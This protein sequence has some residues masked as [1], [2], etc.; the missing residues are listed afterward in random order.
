MD[1]P[2]DAGVL[3]VAERAIDAQVAHF[4]QEP[5]RISNP[6]DSMNAESSV[7]R[8]RSVYIVKRLGAKKATVF[9]PHVASLGVASAAP[10]QPAVVSLEAQG[11]PIAETVGLEVPPLGA[12]PMHSRR[13]GGVEEQ[14]VRQFVAFESILLP[15]RR[16]WTGR[17]AT[18]SVIDLPAAEATLGVVEIA[19][20]RG[21]ARSIDEATGLIDVL[22]HPVNQ[23]R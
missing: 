19:Q 5:E 17:R 18:M 15:G 7:N 14:D 3:A 1:D 13:P 11:G 2:R 8:G 23:R 9:G 10:H 16:R 4:D 21:P 22:K 12:G 6:F 20:G